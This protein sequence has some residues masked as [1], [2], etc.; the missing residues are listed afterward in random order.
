MSKIFRGR[1]RYRDEGPAFRRLS[2]FLV[3]NTIGLR[4]ELLEI[5]GQFRPIRQLAIRAW[6]KSECLFGR[7]NALFCYEWN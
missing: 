6:L 1:D 2:D 5:G 4:A 7:G 3:S